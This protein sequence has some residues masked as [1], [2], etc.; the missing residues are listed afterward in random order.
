MFS[1]DLTLKVHYDMNDVAA[2]FIQ[3][4][5]KREAIEEI[6]SAWV[7]EQIGKGKDDREPNMKEIYS[8]VIELDLHD[9]SFRTTADTGNDSL[10]LG[11]I[12]RMVLP[13]LDDFRVI[14]L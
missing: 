11:I 4:N 2:C 13:K 3:T 5:A 14:A 9:D 10:T 7:R 8:I 1:P 12:V 6:L